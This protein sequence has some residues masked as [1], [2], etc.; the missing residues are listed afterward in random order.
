MTPVEVV[1]LAATDDDADTAKEGLTNPVKVTI[2]EEL[3]A[4]EAPKERTRTFDTKEG[5]SMTMP[6]M[7]ETAFERRGDPDRVIKILEKDD[8]NA[9]GLK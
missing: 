5:G 4:A 7:D 8:I 1:M 3:L 9:A 6:A 2:N